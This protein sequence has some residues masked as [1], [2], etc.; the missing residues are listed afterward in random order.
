[1]EYHPPPPMLYYVIRLFLIYI[2]LEKY[3][4]FIYNFYIFSIYCVYGIDLRVFYT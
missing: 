2:R 3:L 1:M 4:V